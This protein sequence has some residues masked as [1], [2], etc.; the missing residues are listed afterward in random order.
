MP[1]L[2]D[3]SKAIAGRLVDEWDGPEEFFEDARLLQEILEKLFIL[4]PAECKRLIGAGII[5]KDFFDSI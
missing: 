3:F 5:E 2:D 1:S 4:H